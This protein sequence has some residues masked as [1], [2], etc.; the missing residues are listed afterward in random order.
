[1]QPRLIAKLWELFTP[2]AR[3][4][5]I[6]GV[7]RHLR[8]PLPSYKDFIKEMMHDRLSKTARGKVRGRRGAV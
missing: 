3:D 8:G 2:I 6:R 4:E 5:F 7:K 1:M